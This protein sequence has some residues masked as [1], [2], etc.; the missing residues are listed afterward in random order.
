MEMSKLADMYA[1]CEKQDVAY[2][3]E[4]ILGLPF[5]TLQT[6]KKGLCA[7]V[8]A[9]CHHHI[10]IHPLEV[11][12]NSA[13]AQQVKQFN[14]E[15]F[16]FTVVTKK[17]PSLIPERHNYVIASE[18][19]TR[20][21]YIDSWMFSW[22]VLHFHHYAWTQL[23][24]RFARKYKNLSYLQFY[25]DLFEQCISKDPFFMD[26]YNKQEAELK[27]FFW[28]TSSDTVFDNDNV[29]VVLNQIEW[30]E[31][32]DK[33]Q[34]IISDWARTYFSDLEDDLLE[35]VIHMNTLWVTNM[36]R[37]DVHEEMFDYNIPEY[38]VGDQELVKQPVTYTFSNKY[39]WPNNKD[40]KDKLFY[41]NR[42]GFSIQKIERVSDA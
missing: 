8:E 1:Q 5:E 42:N 31:N 30:H 12:K 3:T 2:Y 29:I 38:I 7:A 21:E 32:R 20:Q 39:R 35:E 16:T 10:D 6:W 24:A 41:K 4:F 18:F 19:M 25:E 26:L 17:Q 23:L 27:S 33:V 34:Q 28:N 36:G 14:Y 11:L 22:L 37:H 13:F 9:G 15:V 40:F